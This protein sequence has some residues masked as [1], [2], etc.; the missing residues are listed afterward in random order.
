MSDAERRSI[1]SQVAEGTL[2][3]DEAAERLASL[4][5]DNAAHDQP[6]G[7]HTSVKTAAGGERGLPPGA[8]ASRI[9]IVGSVR[10][11]QIIGDANVKEASVEGPHDARREGDLLIIEGEGPD[12]AWS[13]PGWRWNWNWA[14]EG[15][16]AEDEE[17]RPKDWHVGYKSGVGWSAGR[18]RNPRVKVAGFPSAA[19]FAESISGARQRRSPALKV[20]VNP[21][22]PLE[23][24]IKAGAMS[25]TGVAA[26]ITAEADAASLQ[27]KG[28]TGP[29][30]AKVNAGKLEAT[31]LIAEGAS[32]IE[33]N[34]GKVD[35]RLD[36]GSSVT[37]TA[38]AELSRVNL[39]GA[40]TR[41]GGLLGSEHEATVGGGAATLAMEVNVGSA[42]V[43]LTDEN[44]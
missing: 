2:S 41:S 17:G 37:I 42:T 28:F 27:I 23:A 34:A 31:G 35:L 16:E 20:R 11:V 25:I 43:A 7:Q 8:P 21:H 18:P 5:A 40:E 10:M 29:L 4:D 26:P 36:A 14:G 32:R 13:Q 1:L 12:V 38:R 24:G 30:D 15:N 33:C 9:R 3:P 6:G 44:G 39:P 22:L 19:A